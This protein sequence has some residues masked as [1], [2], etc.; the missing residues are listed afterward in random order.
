MPT[1]H[2]SQLHPGAPVPPPPLPTKRQLFQE[3]GEADPKARP[4]ATPL[5]RLKKLLDES[6]AAK[7]AERGARASSARRSAS[8]PP[9]A[10]E[11]AGAS[12]ALP[13][14]M[15]PPSDR[16]RDLENDEMAKALSDLS[17]SPLTRR[18]QLKLAKEPQPKGKAKAKAAAK[19][20]GKAKAKAKAKAA[21]KGGADTS[22]APSAEEAKADDGPK[23]KQARKAKTAAGTDGAEGSEKPI[24]EPSHAEDRPV[25]EPPTKKK[26]GPKP[27]S[28]VL[29]SVPSKIDNMDP[30]EVMSY[31][32]KDDQMMRL[33]IDFMQEFAKP[34]NEVPTKENK[35]G[36]PSFEHWQ[37]SP[38]WTRSTCGLL[39]KNPEPPHT[40]VGTFTSG[41][42]GNMLVAFE[43]VRAFAPRPSRSYNLT[44]V[45]L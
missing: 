28:A 44:Y 20:Q 26:R 32:H 31:L 30:S 7:K 1:E 45:L 5:A 29:P 24:P 38:Y 22:A 19:A 39:R 25:E 43:A 6:A 21:A 27:R 36:L 14:T 3:V 12:K 13:A 34:E 18:E 16:K 23:P 33:T 41:G 9:V 37:L 15:E 40:Y 17:G 10:P 35:V 42:S 11:S 4:V 2:D 8:P